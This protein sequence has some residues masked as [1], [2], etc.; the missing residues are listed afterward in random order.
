ML[1]EIMEKNKSRQIQ[2]HFRSHK[3]K[4]GNLKYS[5]EKKQH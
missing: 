5:E 3:T 2:K 1:G 4:L